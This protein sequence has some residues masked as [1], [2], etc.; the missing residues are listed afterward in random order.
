MK[1]RLLSIFRRNDERTDIDERIIHNYRL[2]DRVLFD[3]AAA[4]QV[5]EL[6]EAAEQ[7]EQNPESQDSDNN[8]DN[9]TDKQTDADEAKAAATD[10]Q[11]QDTQDAS[12]AEAQADPADNADVDAQVEKLIQGDLPDSADLDDS[13]ADELLPVDTQAQIE[14]EVTV[15]GM[16]GMV[17]ALLKDNGEVISTDRE[18]I[19]INGS[20]TDKDAILANLKPNQEV[21]ILEDGN[22]L[23]EV[24]EY[25]DEHEDTKYSAIH[26]ITHGNEGVVSINGEIINAE[27]VDVTEWSAIGEH[28][29]QDGDILFYGCNTAKTAEGQALIDTIAEASGADVAASDDATGATGDWDLEYTVGTIDH[30]AV[31]VDGYQYDLD[32]MPVVSYLDENG[33]TQ[34]IGEGQTVPTY[35]LIDSDGSAQIW[36]AGWYVVGKDYNNDGKIDSE[37]AKKGI[38]TFTITGQVTLSGE[39]AQVNLILADGF[40][41]KV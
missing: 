32:G 22:G 34:Y 3:A 26:F 39:N 38:N 2:E 10:G 14:A 19:V 8:K 30:E 29:T 21:L 18:L 37:D 33:D 17:E 7:T 28:L 23:D 24:Q 40:T 31:V 41:L 9:N 11:T 15:S 1:K 16:D 35:T 4:T 6:A 36:T 27:N 20:V 12:A 5:V 13:T 25:L